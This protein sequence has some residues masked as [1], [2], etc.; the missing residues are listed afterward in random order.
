MRERFKS[1]YVKLGITI[2][3]AGAAL[4]LV[5]HGIV[6]FEVV[7]SAW[8]GLSSILSPFIFGLVMA[9]LLCPVY[10]STVRRM[11]GLLSPA[12]KQKKHAFRISRVM[13]TLIS[14]LVLFGIV[15]GLFAMVIPETIRSVFGLIQD[16]PGKLNDLLDWIEATFTYD[17]YPEVVLVFESLVNQFEDTFVAWT[18]DDL[19]PRIGMYMTQISQGVLVTLKMFFNFLIGIIVC[20][21]Y[22]NSKE[23]FKAQAKKFVTATLSRKNADGVFEFAHFADK[24]FGGF[25]NGKLIDSLI[26]GIL[27]FVLMS[28]F[29]M[30]YSVLVSTIVGV[31]N[32]IPFFGPFIG[33]VPSVIIICFVSPVQAL[34]FL[35]LVLVLQQ[36]D[37]NILGPKILGGSTGLSSFWVMFAIIF[38]GGLFGFMG[39]VLGVPVFAVIFFYLSRY[40]GKRLERKK[41]PVETAEYQDFNK[42]DINRKEVL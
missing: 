37:G 18:Q 7:R 8:S 19:L 27:C 24:T 34:Y 26:I 9:Y 32:F 40:I 13:G 11:Y 14:L 25:I 35:L 12:F 22:L 15:G 29:K 31:T 5:Y 2:F 3:A 36:F 16:F 23:L 38:S 17:R 28:V 30:P 10:N 33:A 42:Y 41:M 1:G 6:H 39:M 4:I 21:Y 20:V